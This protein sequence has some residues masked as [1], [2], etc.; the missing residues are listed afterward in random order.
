MSTFPRLVKTF[1]LLDFSQLH[2]VPQGEC[3]VFTA[4]GTVVE[5]LPHLWLSPPLVGTV[6]AT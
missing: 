3:A 5:Y 4:Y 2:R 6:G 1:L